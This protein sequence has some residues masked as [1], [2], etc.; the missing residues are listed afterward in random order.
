MI[1]KLTSGALMMILTLLCGCGREQPYPHVV[2]FQAGITEFENGDTIEISEVRGTKGTF[3]VSGT[4]VVRGR[5][6]LQSRDE[7]SL[8][9]YVTAP[10]PGPSTEVAPSQKIAVKKGSDNFELIATFNSDGW[11]HL[12]FYPASGGKP[13]GSLYFGSEQWLRS[14]PFGQQEKSP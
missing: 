12:S 11:P 3:E 9:L 2:S 4:Y 5:Y 10:R 13:F 6:T 1:A 8:A 7:A 14:K